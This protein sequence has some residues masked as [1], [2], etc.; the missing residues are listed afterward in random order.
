MSWRLLKKSLLCMA[1]SDVLENQVYFASTVSTSRANRS[2]VTSIHP[3][4]LNI[5]RSVVSVIVMRTGEE[6]R[7]SIV[8]RTDSDD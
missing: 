7:R 3:S 6:S 5:R 1:F 2:N 4:K 8:Q